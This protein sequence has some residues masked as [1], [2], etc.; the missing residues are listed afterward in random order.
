[1]F[2]NNLDRSQYPLRARFWGIFNGTLVMA[3]AAATL[4]TPGTLEVT[5]PICFAGL[6][7]AALVRNSYRSLIPEFGAGA[8]VATAF[9]AFAMLS[10]L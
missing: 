7:A 1:M 9:L 5:L 6:V 2:P 4:V 10:A 8:R 3:A